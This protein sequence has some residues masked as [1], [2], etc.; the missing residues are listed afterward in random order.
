MRVKKLMSKRLITVISSI[1]NSLC[2]FTL[3]IAV[4]KYNTYKIL[5][6]TSIVSFILQIIYALVFGISFTYQSL[7]IIFLYGLIILA[8]YLSYIKALQNIPIGLASLLENTDIFI[9]LTIDIILGY[10]KLTNRF[11]ILFILF[12]ISIVWFCFE[13]NKI[14]D[15]IKLKKINFIGIVF[16]LLSVFFYV[17]EPYIIK[18]ANSLGANEVAINFGY[19]FLAIPFFLYKCS[20]NKDN[21]STKQNKKILLIVLLIGLFEAIYYIGG[22]IGYI[23]ET[24]IIV[25]IIQEI[26]VFIL[27]ILSFI[28]KTDKINLKKALSI[29]LGML[30]IAGIYLFC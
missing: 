27:V 21:N 12:I 25:N 29:A 20:K 22:T 18:E 16:I 7:S 1:S 26:R 5:L 19:Y 8:G 4:N 13:T 14:K 6:L 3:D 28:F 11:I 23:Y 10:I 24:P 9:V 17:L 30:S 2:D 15:E